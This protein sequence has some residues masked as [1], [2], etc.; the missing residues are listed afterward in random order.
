[1]WWRLLAAVL[2]IGF[3]QAFVLMLM[4]QVFFDP[5]SNVLGIPTAAGLVDLLVCGALFVIL[6]KIPGWVLRVAL[7]RAPRT[8]AMGLV[9][10]AAMAAIGTAIGAPG[11][12]SARTL[13]GRLT[14]RAVTASIGTAT[15]RPG[16]GPRASWPRPIPPNFGTAHG[17]PATGGQG[18][19]FPI[20]KGARLTAQQ[21][22]RRAAIRTGHAKGGWRPP[23]PAAAKRP[24]F[25][26][27]SLFDRDGHITLAATP[28]QG[29]RPAR[30]ARQEA[31]FPIPQDAQ[32]LTGAQ[33]R[34]RREQLERLALGGDSWQPQPATGRSPYRATALFS[35]QGRLHPDVKSAATPRPK[36]VPATPHVAPTQSARTRSSAAKTSPPGGTASTGQRVPKALSPPATGAL[37]AVS[38]TPQP[39]P[40]PAPRLVPVRMA[41][42]PPPV[43]KRRGPS[44][45]DRSRGGEQP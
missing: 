14:G 18:V 9:R 25:Q 28:G 3:L 6:L 42:P 36:D 31:L 11:A 38:R 2:G 12:S 1:L 5:D 8:G 16:T 23:P 26:Q 43:R 45:S 22:R 30:R 21:V 24:R 33:A 4:L 7:G 34:Q 44:K 17:R 40:A 10:T 19:L 15:A 41:A 35:R 39:P 13:V 27:P 37:S 32:R 29:P 20:P